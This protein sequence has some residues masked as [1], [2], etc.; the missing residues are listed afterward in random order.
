MGE[1]DC[2]EL[3]KSLFLFLDG[4][5]P[6]GRCAELTRHLEECGGCLERIGVE[7][8]F[9]ELVRRKCGQEPVPGELVDRIRSALRSQV[10]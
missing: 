3:I 4:E 8:S 9:K 5:L 1:A 2:R 6:A 10:L 7:R